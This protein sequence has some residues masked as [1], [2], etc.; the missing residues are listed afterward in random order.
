MYSSGYNNS[1]CWYLYFAI[2]VLYFIPNNENRNMLACY[3]AKTVKQVFI[4]NVNTGKE[5]LH[6][7][8]L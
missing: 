5:I 3:T 6:T 1:A 4:H 2:T 8:T 7:V